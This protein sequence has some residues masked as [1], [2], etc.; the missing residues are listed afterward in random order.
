MENGW[1]FDPASSVPDLYN[2]PLQA[3]LLAAPLRLVGD[4]GRAW[5]FK[6]PRA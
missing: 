3:L 4:A 1:R 6:G 5:I 2:E